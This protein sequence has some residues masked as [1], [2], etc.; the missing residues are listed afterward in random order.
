MSFSLSFLTTQQPSHCVLNSRH[1]AIST[2]QRLQK[3]PLLGLISREISTPH[4]KLIFVSKR[5]LYSARVYQISA[6]IDGSGGDDSKDRIDSFLEIAE[7]L[8]IASSAIFTVGVAVYSTI[9]NA[10]TVSI[11]SSP[12]MNWSCLAGRLVAW[13]LVLLVGAL[14]IGSLI[15]TRR[16]S[17]ISRRNSDR[18]DSTVIERIEKLEEEVRSSVTIIRVLSRQLEK[19]GIR[20]RVTRKSLKGPIAET[21]ALA[22]KNSEVTRALTIQEDILEKELGEVQKVLLA[23]QEQQQKQLELILAIA[24]AGRLKE[25]NQDTVSKGRTIATSKS[26]QESTAIEEMETQL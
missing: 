24:K 18:Q 22:Q 1:F 25:N 15:R 17:R 9:S 4:F 2:R 23:M 21:A 11:S 16:W 20:F 13:Q 19:L 5:C 6:D 26:V 12:G 8:C 3:Q 10:H 14:G 7:V